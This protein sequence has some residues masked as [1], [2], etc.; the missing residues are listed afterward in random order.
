MII[1]FYITS[2]NI[3][4]SAIPAYRQTGAFRNKKGLKSDEIL[5]IKF[6]W[7]LIR[8]RRRPRAMPVDEC[9]KCR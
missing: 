1:S 3:F 5:G 6:S 7:N 9:A 4:Q 8:L 2:K